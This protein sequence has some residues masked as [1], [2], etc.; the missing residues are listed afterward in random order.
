MNNAPPSARAN[1]IEVRDLRVAF[2]TP[3]GALEALRGINFR[4]RER[5]TVALVGES[6]SGKSVTA[7]VLMGLLPRVARIAS[8]EVLFRDPKTGTVSDLAKIS[9]ATAEFRAIRGGRISIVFQEPM[10]S[11][12]PLHRVG[13][14]IQE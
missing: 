1:I 7:Q 6:G 12:S 11:M 2:D 8:G 10:T 9:P 5:E 14:Q 13:D 4:I 3:G